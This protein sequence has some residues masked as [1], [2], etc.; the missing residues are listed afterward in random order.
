MPAAD[1]SPRAILAQL[2][3]RYTEL[4]TSPDMLQPVAS[5]ASGRMIMR[6]NGVLGIY[7]TDARADNNSFLPAAHGLAACG[8]AVPQILAEL[9][10]PD[11]CGACVVQDMGTTDLL[12]LRGADSAT[13]LAAYRKTLN[14]LAA[15]GQLQPNWPL[16]PAFDAAMYLWEQSYFAEH[17]LEHHLRQNAA[18]FLNNPALQEMANWL[19]EQP[20]VPVH[21]DFQSQNVMLAADGTP[22]MIDFQGM[23]MGLAEYDLA[24]LLCDPY[25]ELSAHEQ[26][27]LITHWEALTGKPLQLDLYCAA[28]M[29]RLMQALGAFAN[30]GYN[31]GKTWYL[32][33]IPAGLAAL[34]HIAQ[35]TPTHSPATPVAT[36]LL[37]HIA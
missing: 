8:I 23:R 20:R 22:H 12:S 13:R 2:I 17:L 1:S 9:S 37:H 33:R 19:A 11:N 27:Q 5:G 28:A 25:M 7:W 6:A 10:L 16:Q 35:I 34:R 32:D 24:S 31:M 30:I 3:S 4:S 15:F 14:M 26:Q 18:D 36:C 29:Q 21:R